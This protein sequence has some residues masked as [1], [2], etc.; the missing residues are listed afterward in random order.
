MFKESE[1]MYNVSYHVLL[2]HD[3]VH[4]V[5]VLKCDLIMI[6]PISY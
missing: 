5:L 4:L 3:S 1:L 2:Y 6:L